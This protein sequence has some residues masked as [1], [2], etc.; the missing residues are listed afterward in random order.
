MQGRFWN[1]MLLLV[2]SVIVAAS[3]S[4]SSGRPAIAAETETEHGTTEEAI[5]EEHVEDEHAG[6][7]GTAP[8]AS[9]SVFHSPLATT[10]PE[11][12]VI[13]NQPGPLWL[14]GM[15]LSNQ[16]LVGAN[17]WRANLRGANLQGS[18]LTGV[19]LMGAEMTSANLSNADADLADM[20][21]AD[22]SNAQLR[23]TSLRDANLINSRLEGANLE[24]ADLSGADLTGASLANADLSGAHYDDHTTW[25]AGFDAAAAVAAPPQEDHAASSPEQSNGG[26]GDAAGHE[27]T[28]AIPTR[29]SVMAIFGI[30]VL[31]IVL[32]LGLV[33]AVIGW[34][35]FL[36]WA[37]KRWGVEA[38]A[39]EDE[40][41][42]QSTPS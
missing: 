16:N 34:F 22:L 12:Y 6:A 27:A 38:M 9:Q 5:A 19:I 10:S 37:D 35:W 21:V 40:K 20:Q 2:L 30:I 15:D 28:Q 23:N 7:E 17:L 25:P 33:L 29:V 39:E 18:D 13:L 31:G 42:E 1:G 4:L 3:A 26:Q 11:L 32:G 41:S 36:I 8:A 14:V 24:G